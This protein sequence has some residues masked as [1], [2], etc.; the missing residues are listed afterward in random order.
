MSAPLSPR[1]AQGQGGWRPGAR[2]ASA[3]MTPTLLLAVPTALIGGG[4]EGLWLALL[5]IVAPLFAALLAVS[6]RAAAPRTGEGPLPLLAVLLVVGLVLWANL[7]LAGDVAAWLGFPRWRGILPIAGAALGLMLGPRAS[8]AWPWLVPL[9][10]VALLLPL[11]VVVLA[12]NV[13]PIATWSQ[14][15]MQPAFRFAP[16]S[17]WVTEGR[18]VGSGRASLTLLFEEEHRV[19]P[20]DAGP[21]RVEV[22]DRGRVQVREWTLAAGQ[23]V[24]LRPGDRLQVG[25]PRRLKFEAGKRVPGAPSSGIAWADSPLGGRSLALVRFL[26]LGLTLLGGAVALVGFAAPVGMARSAVG[27]GGLV[28]LAGL[29]WAEC[30]AVYAARWAPEV[31]LGGVTVP[32]LLE[33]PALVL[34]G[35]PWGSRLAGITLVG[36]SAAFLAGS[37]ALREQVASAG[38][39]VGRALGSDP[40]LWSSIF[41]VTALASLWSVEPWPLL[42]SALGLGA[43]TVAPVILLGTPAGRPRAAT[44]AVGMG[45]VLFVGLTAV[46][47]LAVPASAVAQMVVAYPALVAAPVAAGVLWVARRPAGP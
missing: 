14:V 21:L 5:F 24:T 11:A 29:A 40:G 4:R 16:E 42:L 15:A 47:R 19:T 8:R 2:F 12:S 44:W 38:G 31:F 41:G 34:R 30:W 9:A 27:V 25:T 32:S 45:L 7:S 6:R 35:N 37:V 20:V 36:L 26:G 39:K 22:S 13:S 33:L 3:W 1:T 46:G 23:S 43:S 17:P 18:A 10:L 28:L